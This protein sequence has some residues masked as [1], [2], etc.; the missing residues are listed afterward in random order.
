MSTLQLDSSYF[1]NDIQIAGSD[2][3][4]ILSAAPKYIKKLLKGC[5][6]YALSELVLNYNSDTSEQRI[7]DIVEGCVYSEIVNGKSVQM[8]WLGL[9]NSDKQTPLA[10]FVFANYLNDNSAPKVGVGVAVSQAE[11]STVIDSSLK[12]MNTWNE[13]RELMGCEG[14][15]KNTPSLY[16][17][18]MA[19][20]NTY[21]ELSFI[22]LNLLTPWI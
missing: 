8:K 19:N 20:E 15:N 4:Y 3:T 22:E 12:I 13:A 11:N 9:L 17:F 6:G 14:Q 10:Y 2:T 21:P 1:I 18:L 5:L 7:K 16:N